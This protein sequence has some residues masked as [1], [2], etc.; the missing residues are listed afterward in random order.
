MVKVGESNY[1]LISVRDYLNKNKKKLEI[2]SI[3]KYIKKNK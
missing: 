2:K 1:Q 3:S